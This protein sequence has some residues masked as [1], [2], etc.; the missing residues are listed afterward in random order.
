[1]EA[2]NG[3]AIIGTSPELMVDS[4]VCTYG[5]GAHCEGFSTE[6]L[7]TPQ[8]CA[9][10]INALELLPGSFA[11]RSFFR[12]KVVLC[13]RLQMDN[14]SAVR[15]VNH[16]GRSLLRL[17]ASG[18][19]VLGLLFGVM[20][21]GAGI[22]PSGPSQFESRLVFPPPEE[23]QQVFSHLRHYGVL[24]RLNSLWHAPTANY[25]GT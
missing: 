12:N 16:L 5:C 21:R 13:I 22:I 2:R 20:D 6:G 17:G 11:I 8:E 4:G 23:F 24:Y 3:K 15:Y 18:L 10:H 9:L 25:L 19:R 1:M 7:W 14:F